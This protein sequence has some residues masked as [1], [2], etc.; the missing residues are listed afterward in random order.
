MSIFDNVFFIES[1][2]SLPKIIDKLKTPE[3]IFKYMR[4]NIKYDSSIDWKLKS[5]NQ[6]YTSKKG[7]CHDQAYFIS[8]ALTHIGVKNGRIFFIEY[9]KNENTGG[10]THTLTY[11]VI[12]AIF[13]LLFAIY[14]AKILYIL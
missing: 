3:D 9:N 5:L 6:I 8:K 1:G 11:F 12:F 10:R 13:V 7:N 2:T 14:F 4:N